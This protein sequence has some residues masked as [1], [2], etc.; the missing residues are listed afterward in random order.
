MKKH[1]KTGLIKSLFAILISSPAIRLDLSLLFGLFMN[2]VYIVENFILAII[3]HSIW[4]ATVTVYHSL[5]VAIRAY[6]LRWRG[7]SEAHE[8]RPS[9]IHRIC[10]RVGV[11]LLLLD[12]AASVMM[13][14]TVLLD[15]HTEYSG[16]A[17]MGFS[18]YTVYSLASSAFGMFK[19][20]NDNK[21]LHFAAR[22]TTLAAALMSVFNLQYSLFA[23]LGADS[24]LIGRANA[25]CGFLIFIIIII[26]ALHL[27]IKNAF[28]ASIEQRLDSQNS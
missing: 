14:Y 13:L 4:S 5:F 6:L 19:W 12:F 11:I 21:P 22:N 28:A 7:L 26:L 15:R 16:I 10:L 27:I 23:S 24:V 3:Y 1:E 20:S 9:E 2:I 17:L 18:L 25:A 8:A